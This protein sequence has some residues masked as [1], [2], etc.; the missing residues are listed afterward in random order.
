MVTLSKQYK[1]FLWPSVKLSSNYKATDTFLIKAWASHPGLA[2]SCGEQHACVCLLTV[3]FLFC[4]SAPAFPTTPNISPFSPYP[5]AWPHSSH[6]L[7]PHIIQ[8]VLIYHVHGRKRKLELPTLNSLFSVGERSWAHS[9][10]AVFFVVA[11]EWLGVREITFKKQKLLA[12]MCL[13]FEWGYCWAL[14]ILNMRY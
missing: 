7:W 5:Q 13:I 1:H 3:C 8:D 10:E 2:R 6:L 9:K 14:Y 4:P 12:D 11:A